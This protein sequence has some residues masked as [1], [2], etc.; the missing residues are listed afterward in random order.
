[1]TGV[2]TCALPISKDTEGVH[3]YDFFIENL[4][5]P[6]CAKPQVIDMHKVLDDA[7]AQDEPDFTKLKQILVALIEDGQRHDYH[8]DQIGRASCR[9]RV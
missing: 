9:E 8:G 4:Q 3:Y 2:Q 1:M 7:F 6:D 5:L